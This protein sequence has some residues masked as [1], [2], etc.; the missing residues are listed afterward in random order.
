MEF[1][2]ILRAG[3]LLQQ[4]IV[5]AWASSDQARLNWFRTH[6]STIRASLYSRLQDAMASADDSVNLKSIGQQT[7]LPS[8]YIGGARHM[9]G[10]FQDSMVIA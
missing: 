9:H 7:V 5:D 8:S 4:Y 3:K 6:Q 2:T 10:I 1:S